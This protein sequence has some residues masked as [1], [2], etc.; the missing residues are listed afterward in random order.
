MSAVSVSSHR[1]VCAQPE[2][3]TKIAIDRLTA[4]TMKVVGAGAPAWPM[5]SFLDSNNMNFTGEHGLIKLPSIH[6]FAEGV[7]IVCGRAHSPSGGPECAVLFNA[8]TGRHTRQTVTF[9]T[10]PL[11]WICIGY[12]DAIIRDPWQCPMCASGGK[13]PPRP[14]EPPFPDEGA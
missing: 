11:R 7:G 14:S 2:L 1:Q 5:T 12:C 6:F 9:M 3:A 8:A 10:A 4:E 13:S